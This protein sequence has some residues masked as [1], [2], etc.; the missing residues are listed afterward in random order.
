MHMYARMYIEL[1]KTTFYY[2]RT[3][4]TN[5]MIIIITIGN[6]STSFKFKKK[7]YS[8]NPIRPGGRQ[9]LNSM[10]PFFSSSLYSFF[11]V[12]SYK[13]ASIIIDLID[14]W[15]DWL[16]CCIQHRRL[17]QAEK[18]I[19]KPNFI[20]FR[21]VVYYLSAQHVDFYDEGFVLVWNRLQSLPIICQDFVSFF[22]SSSLFPFLFF[23]FL[24]K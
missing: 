10:L 12:L 9:Q 17:S 13:W 5:V 15:L 18:N 16:G 14:G 6:I 23:F 24:W 1:P 4:I 8:T 19:F 20:F 7:I 2:G 21:S 22:F 11:F 3:I